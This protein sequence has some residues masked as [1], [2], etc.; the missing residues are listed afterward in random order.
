[1]NL[2]TQAQT[3]TALRYA[4]T[5]VGSAASILV[6]LGLI[7]ANTS[8][9]LIAAFHKFFDDLQALV[10]DVYVIVGIAGPIIVVWLGKIGYSSASPKNQT[11]SALAA[12]PKTV[13]AAVNA[14]PNA[15]VTVSDPALATPGVKVGPVQ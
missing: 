7:D 8:T 3:N 13:I 4:G 2:P 9:Q 5:T 15:S 12:E 10:G 1:M 14:L 11:A 6:L